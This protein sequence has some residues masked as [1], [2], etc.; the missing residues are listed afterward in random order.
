MKARIR[1]IKLIEE[2]QTDRVHIQL[3]SILIIE[4][5]VIDK[6]YILCRTKTKS[7]ATWNYIQ[8]VLDFLQ[9]YDDYSTWDSHVNTRL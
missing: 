2:G 8:V 5:L 7:S 3:C 4:V 1:K 6:L 9:A